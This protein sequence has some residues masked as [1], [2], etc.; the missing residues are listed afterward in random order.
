MGIVNRDGINFR[1]LVL[2][3]KIKETSK[4]AIYMKEVVEI[5]KYLK[6]NLEPGDLFLTIGAGDVYKIG[7]EIIEK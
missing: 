6:E 7:E 2:V 5:E 4:N 1:E 3:D